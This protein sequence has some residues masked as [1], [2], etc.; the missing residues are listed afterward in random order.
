MSNTK[1]IDLKVMTGSIDMNVLRFY[2]TLDDDERKAFSPWV[3]M[4]YA[5]SCKGIYA[6]YYLIMVNE[7]VNKDFNDLAKHPKLQ[8]QLLSLCG[9]GEKQFHPWIAPP[10]KGKKSKLDEALIEIYPNAKLDDILLLRQLNS[11]AE[12]TELFKSYGYTDKQIKA[13][14]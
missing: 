5:S 10:K 14:F 1:K 6:G 4:R 2:D 9:V 7:F 11:K 8:W 12:L 3:A 13:L